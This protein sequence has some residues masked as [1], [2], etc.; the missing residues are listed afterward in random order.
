MGSQRGGVAVIKAE[1]T[2][3]LKGN[4]GVG[5]ERKGQKLEVL[6]KKNQLDLDLA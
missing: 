5:L 2:E 1:Y 6:R 4:L 3:V